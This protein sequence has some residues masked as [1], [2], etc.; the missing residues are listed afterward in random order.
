M[1]YFG[2]RDI[3]SFKIVHQLVTIFFINWLYSNQNM[4]TWCESES[5]WIRY[6]SEGDCKGQKAKIN[7]NVFIYVLLIISIY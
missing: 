7:K 6:T 3:K 1:H 2:F 4:I 5:T